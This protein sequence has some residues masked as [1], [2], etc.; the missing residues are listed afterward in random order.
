MDER[1]IAR[2]IEAMHGMNLHP[3]DRLFQSRIAGFDVEND[4]DAFRVL[5]HR[6][7][8]ALR[9]AG[10]ALHVGGDARHAHR[11]TDRRRAQAW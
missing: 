11:A 4:E 8:R 2:L 6:S 5:R 10:A 3:S 1:P 9:H 7:A